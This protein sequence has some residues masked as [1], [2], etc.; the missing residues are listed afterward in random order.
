MNEHPQ[1]LVGSRRSGSS[2]S[3]PDTS[4]NAPLSRPSI[5]STPEFAERVGAQFV[6]VEELKE[7]GAGAHELATAEKTLQELLRN[8]RQRAPRG[9]PTL[10]E[11]LLSLHAHADILGGMQRRLGSGR[12]LSVK[13]LALPFQ[14]ELL[15]PQQEFN[16]KLATVLRDLPSRLTGAQPGNTPE[17][18]RQ[19]LEPLAN[20]S[21][22]RF[23]SHRAGLAAQAVMLTKKSGMRL[24]RRQLRPAFEQLRKWNSAVIDAL[25]AAHGEGPRARRPSSCSRAWTR[26]P[27]CPRWIP[28]CRRPCARRSPR[29]GSSPARSTRR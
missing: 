29:S 6:L 20:P 17:W 5:E 9:A 10:Q 2:D 1:Q 27:G 11:D 16:L 15:R 19:T 21:V 7:K 18:I 13:R 22:W 4:G 24:Q 26:W 14:V 23:Q 12:A 8:L 3:A 25:C 28:S